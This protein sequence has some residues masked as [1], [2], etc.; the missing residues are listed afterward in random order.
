MAVSSDIAPPV[1]LRP[2]GDDLSQ[3]GKLL[4]AVRGKR[5]PIG[6]GVEDVEIQEAG[7]ANAA[8]LQ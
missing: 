5:L 6:F 2:Q 3:S 4:E 1:S 7:T 8:T